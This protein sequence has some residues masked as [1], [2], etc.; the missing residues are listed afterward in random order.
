MPGL[1]SRA[2]PVPRTE[3]G[4]DIASPSGSVWLDDQVGHHLVMHEPAVLQTQ[5]AISAGR[6]EGV[7][8]AVDVAR[9]RLGLCHHLHCRI[10]DPKPVITSALVTCN[11]TGLPTTR[12]GPS[13]VHAH[14][15]PVALTITREAACGP[16]SGYGKAR[17]VV[18]VATAMTTTSSQNQPA[19]T[20]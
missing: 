3:E 6:R 5:D 1:R 20:R 19:R 9:H 12:S 10:V 18:T 17:R 15:A 7:L 11:S 13:I 14:C 8:Q 4:I 2:L 16:R